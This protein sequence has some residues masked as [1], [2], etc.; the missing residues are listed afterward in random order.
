MRR[1]DEHG[2]GDIV[3]TVSEGSGARGENLKERVK[4]LDL[5]GV[6]SDGVVSRFHSLVRSASGLSSLQTVNIDGGSVSENV[7]EVRVHLVSAENGVSLDRRGA[8]R[9]GDTSNVGDEGI[10]RT[11]R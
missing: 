1:K 5:V 2:V 7:L 3:G 6:R 10:R 4:V 8:L 9:A 11:E